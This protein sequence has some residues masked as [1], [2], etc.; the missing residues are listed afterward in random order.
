MEISTDPDFSP[1]VS[2]YAATTRPFADP[3]TNS[4]AGADPGAEN[5]P[6]AYASFNQPSS[7][8][9]DAAGNL[10]IADTG[11]HQIR[12][13]D[14]SGVVTT[15]AGSTF[16]FINDLGPN[17]KFAFPTAVA[18]GRDNNLYV[19]DTFNHAIRKLTRP[20]APGGSWT[21]TTLAGTGEAGYFDGAG[22]IARF[23][24][25]E[26]LAVDSFG[27]IYV[28]DSANHRIRRISPVGVVSTHAG[29]GSIGFADGA[30]TNAQFN[31]PSGIA[32]DNDG[33]LFIAD[34]DNHLIRRIAAGSAG[35]VSTVAGGSGQAGFIDAT[36]TDARFSSPVAI[37][38]D[39]NNN[40]YIADKNN[41]RIRKITIATRVVSTVAGSGTDGA[42]NGIAETATF[43]CPTSL[44]L[45]NIGNLVV[46]DRDAHALRRIVITNLS[47]T[48][49]VSGTDVQ[50]RLDA[51]QLGIQTYTDYYV[52]W[53]DVDAGT[54]QNRGLT[55]NLVEAPVVA[56]R[57]AAVSPTTGWIN[58]T[59]DPRQSQTDVVFRYS[60]DANLLG[61]LKVDTVA[62]FTST[63]VAMVR[64]DAGNIYVASRDSHKI[65]KIL[66]DGTA[67][68]FTG[69][70]EAGFADGLGSQAQFDTPSDLA[71]DSSGNIYVA[72]ELNH[73]IRKISPAGLVTT[74]AGSGIA[75]FED[76]NVATEG[77]LLFPSG[78]CLHPSANG[79]AVADRGNNRIRIINFS[80]GIST[81]AG[82]GTPGAA[83][84]IGNVAQFNNPTGLAYGQNYELLVADQGNH[85]IRSIQNN[86]VNTLAGTGAAGFADGLAG[87]ALFSSPTG[88]ASDGEGNV[89][90]ADRDN[91]R[92]RLINIAGVVSTLAGSG[93]P[94]L[95]NSPDGSLIPATQT[96]FH[97]PTAIFIAPG[98]VAQD[99]TRT[100]RPTLRNPE[101]YLIDS[102]N[103][104][105]R[106]VTRSSI[107]ETSP[108]AL[109]GGTL[110]DPLQS[111]TQSIP[112]TL[113]PGETYYFQIRASN[114]RGESIGEVL[115]FTTPTEQNI[116]ILNGSELTAP[117]LLNGSQATTIDFGETPLGTLVQKTFTVTND[118][119]WPLQ[120]NGLDIQGQYEVVIVSGQALDLISFPLTVTSGSS[121]VI[122]VAGPIQT[123]LID[124]APQPYV[125]ALQ[126]SSDDPD[127]GV[128]TIPLTGVVLNPPVIRTQQSQDP[129]L[130]TATLRATLNPHGTSTTAWFAYSRDPELDGVDV[131]T[132]AGSTAGFQNGP[133]ESARFDEPLGLATD[134]VGNIYV[135]DTANHRI[136]M[137]SPD[138]TTI[139]VAGNG[140]AGFADGPGADAQFNRPSDIVIGGDGTL[141]VADSLNHRIRAIAPNG[142]VRTAAGTG[143]ASF[144]DGVSSA[145]RF[146]GPSGLA[147]NSNGTLFVADRNNHRVRIVYP[148]GSAAT[149]A[150]TGIAGSVNGAPGTATLNQPVALAIDPEGIIFL[151]ETGSNI[152]RQ[153]AQNG[154]VSEFYTFV[155]LTT[156]RGIAVDLQGNVFIASPGNHLVLKIPIDNVEPGLPLAGTGTA[157]SED[158]MGNLIG[159][160]GP[161]T[162]AQFNSPS[163]ITF[164]PDGSLFVGDAAT[165]AI[166]RIS[167]NTVMVEAEADDPSADFS[168]FE[169]IEVS[170]RAENLVSY[171]HYFFR[172][173]ATN[174]GGSSDLSFTLGGQSP[175]EDVKT[176]IS[177][178][179]T[180]FETWQFNNFGT[181]PDYP[182]IADP[183]KDANNDTVVNLRKYA[184]A[185]DPFDASCDGLPVI[186]MEEGRLV[187]TYT[188]N[189]AA[190]DLIFE[191]ESSLNLALDNW[192]PAEGLTIQRF[193]NNGVTERVI[194]SVP[195]L[196]DT[197]PTPGDPNPALGLRLRITLITQP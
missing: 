188:R 178:P 49:G 35:G 175:L 28:A 41:R 40:L 9:E 33:N 151:T 80:A 180:P 26:G 74:I 105:I 20:G 143:E 182:S 166:R 62:T 63:P 170:R 90:V 46:A 99:G 34:R 196:P 10:F 2:T 37:A 57:E 24:R 27:Q 140:N 148:D 76:S 129:T 113:W 17:A 142:I 141:Y 67:L 31:Y 86:Q 174:E 130:T 6:R 48:A 78:V 139:T 157:G 19:A 190:T 83:D 150:G 50:G 186:R 138:G 179:R 45:D 155:D 195:L 114:E 119:D 22:T 77:K 12:M 55:F 73:R 1:T 117:Q 168:G 98:S 128:F 13:L 118:G 116:I 81:L 7:I 66:P 92:L 79:L 71:I 15:I 137:I 25:P 97:S 107:N 14:T 58:G 69:S 106:S 154:Q 29:K 42:R 185:I 171:V 136:R 101:I 65:T 56:T 158:G 149:M 172:A 189:L 4:S 32:F 122:E 120:I 197:A 167:S 192:V 124:G 100:G 133:N 36:G 43:R 44:T 16:G 61:P 111:I 18:I 30:K 153:I 96:Q 103:N 193:Q 131:T 160:Q 163:S 88:V 191:V 162:A 84:G 183:D 87:N 159:V 104:A 75:G 147:I 161:A 184:H 94:G 5:G 109:P 146:N 194:A 132:V 145:V 123:Q 156:L 126:I 121:L 108:P 115:S 3:A 89:Y 64:D 127:S 59:V 187:M 110:G 85:A 91:H 135:A 82:S 181:H 93:S 38:I 11:N 52:R 112:E 39:G 21:V 54:T 102:T 165:G 53:V 70:G 177:R 173:F 176:F 68:D 125:G 95:F 164:G 144:T 134:A 152:V 60:T 51:A 169:T 8:A 72:D 47:V 23:S